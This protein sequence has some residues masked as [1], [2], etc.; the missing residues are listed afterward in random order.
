M[1]KLHICAYENAVK[2]IYIFT[3]F[4]QLR[5]I[6]IAYLIKTY[7]FVHTKAFFEKRKISEF[8]YIDFA[9]TSKKMF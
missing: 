5:K 8:R 2:I 7:I 3:Y 9:S 1:Q 4:A 6:Y